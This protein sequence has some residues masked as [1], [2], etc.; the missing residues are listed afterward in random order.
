M[1]FAICNETFRE[2]DFPGTCAGVAGT[3]PIPEIIRESLLWTSHFH[4]NDPRLCATF[5]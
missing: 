1:R 3:K 5:Y 4:A 2:G